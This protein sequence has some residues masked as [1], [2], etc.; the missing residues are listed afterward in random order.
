MWV[1]VIN[2]FQETSTALSI[3]NVHDVKIGFFEILF[4]KKND[5]AW[6]LNPNAKNVIVKHPSNLEIT[7]TTEQQIAHG[8]DLPDIHKDQRLKS[9]NGRVANGA[10]VL[11]LQNAE[12]YSMMLLP[13]VS[14]SDR[15][16]ANAVRNREILFKHTMPV[17]I[18]RLRLNGCAL[19]A[20]HYYIIHLIRLLRRRMKYELA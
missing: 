17:I 4:T 19:I 12:I 1:W 6:G 2:V 11:S 15:K 3:G 13:M 16:F 7:R 18:V 14:L 9:G 10:H 8:C 5:Q 20:I